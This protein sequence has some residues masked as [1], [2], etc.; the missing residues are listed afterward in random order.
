[1]ISVVLIA[2]SLTAL[3]LLLGVGS[4]VLREVWALLG[5]SS[6]TLYTLS[7]AIVP[8]STLNPAARAV[9]A[10]LP[11]RWGIEALHH[12]LAG[13]GFS[14]LMPYFGG[15]L[16]VASAVFALGVGALR[17]YELRALRK[18]SVDLV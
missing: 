16:L 5:V 17:L 15:E 8:L 6:V 10:V 2:V 18:G 14:S 11:S 13:D 3:G 9:S 4:L 1:V 12:S 7:G